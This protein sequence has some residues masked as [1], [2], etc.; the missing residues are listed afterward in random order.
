MKNI[1][2]L[3]LFPCICFSQS[4]DYLPALNANQVVYHANYTLSY[5]EACEQAEWVAYELKKEREEMKTYLKAKHAKI[6]NI[7]DTCLFP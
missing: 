5:S 1:L 2:L 7:N 4:F 6:Q 3:L